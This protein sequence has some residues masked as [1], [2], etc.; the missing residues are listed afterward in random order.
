[1]LFLADILYEE[2]VDDAPLIT[3]KLRDA[4]ILLIILFC[5]QEQEIRNK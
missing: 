4:N 2:S 1:M 5:L 3:P